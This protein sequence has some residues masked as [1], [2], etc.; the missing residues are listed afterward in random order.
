MRIYSL[1]NATVQEASKRRLKIIS[2]YK[3]IRLGDIIGLRNGIYIE[4]INQRRYAV[5]ILRISL[6][7]FLKTDYGYIKASDKTFFSD[8]LGEFFK[9]S[10]SD[11]VFM[12]GVSPAQFCD[13]KITCKNCS[14]RMKCKFIH[15]WEAI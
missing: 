9:S 4:V 1:L 5:Y 12:V 8:C 10:I 3:G 11:L 6:S 7:G 2:R 13:G 15:R 14:I